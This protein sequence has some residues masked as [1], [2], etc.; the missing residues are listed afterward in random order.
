MAKTWVKTHYQV[1]FDRDLGSA[2][3][4]A[5]DGGELSEL[6][7]YHVKNLDPTLVW[8]EFTVD[9]DMVRMD[10]SINKGQYAMF[11]IERIDP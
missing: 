5:D 1:R 2:E 9:V 4:W 6:I 11:K 3:F 10:G 8:R 7:F